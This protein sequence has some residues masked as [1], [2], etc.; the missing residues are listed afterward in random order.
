M[1]DILLIVF[2]GLVIVAIVAKWSQRRSERNK[3]SSEE[4]EEVQDEMT[5]IT[6]GKYTIWLRH[7]EV[8]NFNEQPRNIRKTLA[9]A[10]DRKVR[11]R[12]LVPIIENG[13][14]LGYVTPQ[15]KASHEQ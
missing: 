5:S 12:E 11:K 1:S 14:I 2:F 7:G 8:D 4:E 13:K 9:K 6:M 10:F 15:E 3:L